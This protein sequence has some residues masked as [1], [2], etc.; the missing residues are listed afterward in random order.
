MEA[1]AEEAGGD[2]RHRWRRLV[3]ARVTGGGGWWGCASL[4]DLE[5]CVA[6]GRRSGVARAVPSLSLSL[7]LSV[8]RAVLSLYLHPPPPWVWWELG[9]GGGGC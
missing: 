8:T 2:A 1:E 9:G 7:C 5:G 6:G 3:G 4:E